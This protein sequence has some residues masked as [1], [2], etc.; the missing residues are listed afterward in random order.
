MFVILACLL[1]VSDLTTQAASRQSNLLVYW[2]WA[3][4]FF[5]FAIGEIAPQAAL[6]QKPVE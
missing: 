1:L 3:H 4:S 6:D 5:D 2:R